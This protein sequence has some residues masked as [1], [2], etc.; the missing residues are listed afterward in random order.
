MAMDAGCYQ[1]IV[2]LGYIY[3]YGRTGDPDYAKALA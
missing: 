3:E 2:N 1:S